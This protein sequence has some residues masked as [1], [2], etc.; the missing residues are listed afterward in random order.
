MSHWNPFNELKTDGNTRIDTLSTCG[1]RWSIPNLKLFIVYICESRRGP[2]VFIRS[3]FVF[4][5]GS[6]VERV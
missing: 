5:L 3:V 6:L 1:H 2:C 4:E